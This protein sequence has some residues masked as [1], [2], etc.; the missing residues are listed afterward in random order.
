MGAFHSIKKNGVNFPKFPEKRTTSY[1]K[2]PFHL[3]SL[4]AFPYFPLSRSL[5]RNSI[6]S[7]FFKTYSADHVFEIFR[8]FVLNGKR[9]LFFHSI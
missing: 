5:F 3:T 6:I 7:R 8:V 4:S 2:F 9:L 1:R